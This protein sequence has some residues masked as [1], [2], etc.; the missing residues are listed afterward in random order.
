MLAM[1]RRAIA[2][3]EAA[4]MRVG[5]VLISGRLTY[6]SRHRLGD[7][8]ILQPSRCASLFSRQA[9]RDVDSQ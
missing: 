3:E 5:G 1:P 8:V 6:F 9:G 4:I 7:D 2:S